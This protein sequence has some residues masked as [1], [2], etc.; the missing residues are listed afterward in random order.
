M[1]SDSAFRSEFADDLTPPGVAHSGQS[2]E[3]SHAEVGQARIG[4]CAD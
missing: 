2:T 3:V 4:R 1:T